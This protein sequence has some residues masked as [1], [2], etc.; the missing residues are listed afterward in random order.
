V[1]WLVYLLNQFFT[2][3]EIP[4]TVEFG[5]GLYTPH[6]NGIVLAPQVRGG[7]NVVLFSGV[8]LGSASPATGV[9]HHRGDPVLGDGVTV[10]TKATVVGPV[11]IGD[12]ATIG[13]HALVLEDVAAHIVVAGAPARPV[14]ELSHSQTATDS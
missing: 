5:P 13:A 4:P 9:N 8:V 3:A 14:H 7:R 6:P 12:W 10:F 2:G 11:R 1:G